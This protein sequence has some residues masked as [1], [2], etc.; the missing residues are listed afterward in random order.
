MPLIKLESGHNLAF[1]GYDGI[2][3]CVILFWYHQITDLIITMSITSRKTTSHRLPTIRQLQCFMVVCQELNFRKASERLNMTQPPLTRQ[4]QSLEALIGKNLFLRNTHE[5]TLTDTG[6]QLLD[7]AEKWLSQ[8]ENDM[9]EIANSS[10]IKFGYTRFL[11]FENIPAIFDKLHAIEQDIATI[12][13]N[14]SSP[15]LINNLCKGNLDIILIGEGNLSDDKVRYQKI[16]TEPLLLVMPSTHHASSQEKVSLQDVADLP[17]YWFA[18]NEHPAYFDKCEAYFISLDFRLK[19]LA[20]PKD[21]LILLDKIAKGR[22]MALMPQSLCTVQQAGCCYKKLSDK[23][24]QS[25]NIVV[26]IAIR[27]GET[28]EKILA[29]FSQFIA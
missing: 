17:L 20:E 29:I 19:R 27:Q 13:E 11:N 7:K 15:Q 2:F 26:F 14:L 8:L 28:D 5:V 24:N 10:T 12:N 9:A 18:R 23:D 22:G 1:I 21:S 25:L 3:K 16:H 4:I 6:Q